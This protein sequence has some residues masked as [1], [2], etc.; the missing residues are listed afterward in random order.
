MSPDTPYQLGQIVQ[1]NELITPG[2]AE[3][4]AA[5]LDIIAPGPGEDIP[6]LWHGVYLLDKAPQS[7]LGT[8]GHR[9]RGGVPLPPGPGR[10]RMFAGGRVRRLGPFRYGAE[11]TRTARVINITEKTGRSGHFEIVTVLHEI[12]QNGALVLSDEQDIVYRPSRQQEQ[13]DSSPTAGEAS[14]GTTAFPGD[15]LVVEIDPV[16][17]FRFSALTYN[18][19]R[20]HYDREFATLVEGYPG[21]VVHGPLQA[22]LMCE[23]ARGKNEP[24][25]VCRFEYRLV[26]PLCEGEGCVVS[27]RTGSEGIE[28]SVFDSNGRMTAHGMLRAG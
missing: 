11:A 21:L 22:L 20:I 7:M 14:P 6:L 26:S 3:A 17:L 24:P 19:H 5:L 13:A 12:S 9:V 27:A 4:L 28:T 10:R 16:R 2:P 15:G 25:L 23:V 8:D 18:A 1:V